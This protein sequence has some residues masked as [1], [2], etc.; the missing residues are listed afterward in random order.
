MRAIRQYEF[1]G[2]DVLR[3]QD[4]PDPVPGAGQVRIDVAAAG[5]HLIDTSVRAGRDGGWLGL[6]ALPMT[7]G[8]EVAGVVGAVGPDVPARWLGRRVVAHLGQANGGYAERAAAPVAA[9]HE[10]PDD[11]AYDAA[12]TMIGTGRTTVG[13]LDEAGITAADV[14]LVTAAAGGIGTLLVQA[15]V[16]AGAVVVGAAGGPDK[17]ALVGKLG[18]DLP[19]DY[20]AADWPDQVRAALGGREVTLGLDGVG[21]PLGRQALELIGAGGR[22]V[23]YGYASGTSTEI[24]VGDLYSRGL[25]VSVAIGARMMKRSGGL[26]PLAERALAA[27]A[28]GELVPVVGRRFPLARAADA[29]R[30]LESRDTVGKVVLEP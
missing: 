27:A 14:V 3:P 6:P 30:A 29:H 16:R 2:P 1:G 20:S 9:L 10:L 5:V 18:A 19:V 25:A 28:A 11:L 8:R 23:L 21:G 4:V 22:L 17:V 24:T 12:V 13:I 7:P 26:R 15:A